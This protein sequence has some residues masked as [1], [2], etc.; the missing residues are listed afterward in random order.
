M[1]IPFLDLYRINERQRTEITDAINQVIDSGWYI[2]G[3]ANQAFCS[4]FA[5]FCGCK[6]VLGVANGLDAL[7]LIIQGYGFGEG[8]EIIVPS[9]TFIASI[10][11]ISQTGCTP[12][13]VEPDLMTYTIDPVLVEQAITSKT[14]AIMVVHLYGQVG[15]MEAL[16]YGRFLACLIPQKKL[17]KKIRKHFTR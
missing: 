14:K 2:Q 12:I 17:R 1:Q 7:K 10:L 15:P 8:D 16:W 11:A 6:Y 5:K 13:L 9:N 3:Q 4:N